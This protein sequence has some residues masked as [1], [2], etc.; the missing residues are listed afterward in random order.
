MHEMSIAQSL[1]EIIRQELARHDPKG[2]LT[3]VSVKHGQLTHIVPDSLYFAFDVL[4]KDTP[5]EG[6]QLVL[7]EVP[8]RVQ[9]SSCNR[10]FEPESEHPL[11]MPCPFCGEECGHEVICGKELYLDRLEVEHPET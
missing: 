5:L 6:A 11:L 8:L 10:E 3:L 7:E 2:R 1:L 9:C 4:T